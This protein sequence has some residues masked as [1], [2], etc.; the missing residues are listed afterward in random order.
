MADQ[1]L[2]ALANALAK[3]MG[4]SLMITAVFPENGKIQMTS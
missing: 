1:V 2:P 3:W 4:A